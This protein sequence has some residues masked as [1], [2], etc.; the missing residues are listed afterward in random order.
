[1]IRWL[2]KNIIKKI[3]VRHLKPGVYTVKVQNKGFIETGKLIIS[4]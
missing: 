4:R 2:V 1:M 3:N